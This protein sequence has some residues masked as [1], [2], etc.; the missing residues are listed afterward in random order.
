[1]AALSANWKVSKRLSRTK[2]FGVK[3]RDIEIDTAKIYTSIAQRQ[4]NIGT[5]QHT[6]QN[7]K[8]IQTKN[9]V[10]NDLLTSLTEIFTSATETAIRTFF[11]VFFK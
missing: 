6:D 3:A 10:Q 9:L 5:V 8:T 7:P 4:A 11:G 2:G 1:M